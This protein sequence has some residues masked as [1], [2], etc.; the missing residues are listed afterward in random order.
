MPEPDRDDLTRLSYWFPR[1]EA[2][3]LPVPKTRI[4]TLYDFQIE[5]LMGIIDGKESQVCGMLAERIRRI[6]YADFSLP[7]FLRTD[8]ISGKHSW[9]DTCYLSDTTRIERHIYALV[10]ESCLA[11][12]FGVPFDTWVV[13]ELLETQPAF[14]AFRGMPITEEWRFFVRD[15]AIDHVQPY[16][17]PES[18]MRP[19]VEDWQDRLAAISTLGDDDLA[20]LTALALRASAAVSGFWSVD[21]LRT[22]DRGWVLI[23][24][25][26]GRKSFRWDALST[27]A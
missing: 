24:M 16:W 11:G 22:R 17:P 15:G 21:F 4:F 7:V 20:A 9:I 23:D 14:T 25:A 5:E 2:A 18:I 12:F 13:R 8:F 27:N 19:S 3:G 26:E 10:E 6:I 1:I